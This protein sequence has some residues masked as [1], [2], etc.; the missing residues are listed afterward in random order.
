[1]R[2]AQLFH[3]GLLDAA[4]IAIEEQAL[5]FGELGGGDGGVGVQLVDGE[6]VLVLADELLDLQAIAAHGIAA[7]QVMAIFSHMHN[8]VLQLGEHGV[9]LV[10]PDEADQFAQLAAGEFQRFQAQQVATALRVLRHLEH[11][12]DGRQPGLH[13]GDVRHAAQLVRSGV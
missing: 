5:Q 13:G 7:R 4:F 12:T 6:V 11:G 2:I 10:T 1:M 9:P 8:A 3:E